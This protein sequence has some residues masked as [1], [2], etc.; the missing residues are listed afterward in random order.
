MN[1]KSLTEYFQSRNASTIAYDTLIIHG[2]IK[3]VCFQLDDGVSIIA[4]AGTC[5]EFRKIITQIYGEIKPVPE[6]ELTCF[7]IGPYKRAFCREYTMLIG[8][9]K[10]VGSE[11]DWPHGTYIW[12]DKW[13]IKHGTYHYGRMKDY[14]TYLNKKRIIKDIFYFI[15]RMHIHG[16]ALF[17][18]FLF[19][20]LLL[21]TLRKNYTNLIEPYFVQPVVKLFDALDL[22]MNELAVEQIILSPVFKLLEVLI[23]NN[24]IKES[25]ETLFLGNK[26]TTVTH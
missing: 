1:P 19:V 18:A 7:S 16:F 15:V 26:N 3:E 20:F 11:F 8:T 2:I 22:F 10:K 13:H 14:K 4:L 6:E 5:K 9:K 24:N 17:F 12:H 21:V 25:V 23:P